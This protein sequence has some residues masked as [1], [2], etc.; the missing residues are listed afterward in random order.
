MLWVRAGSSG[1]LLP[2]F[3]ILA[4]YSKEVGTWRSLV[5]HLNGVQGVRSSNLRVPTKLFFRF[6]TLN[7]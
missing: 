2:V 3:A 7:S 1:L 6:V 5:A 4:F